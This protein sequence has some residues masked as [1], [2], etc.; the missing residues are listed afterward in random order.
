MER[1]RLEAVSVKSIYDETKR[2]SKMTTGGEEREENKKGE[3]QVEGKIC[4]V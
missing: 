4:K 3:Y 1:G 2:K